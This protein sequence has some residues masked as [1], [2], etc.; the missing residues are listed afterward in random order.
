MLAKRMMEGV[1]CFLR[2]FPRNHELRGY[3]AT[4]S[5]KMIDMAAL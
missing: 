2:W 4:W 1:V 3:E 5:A